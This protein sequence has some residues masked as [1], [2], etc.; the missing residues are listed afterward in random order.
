MANG[1]MIVH[2]EGASAVFQLNLTTAASGTE[3]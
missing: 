1:K 3:T 2:G